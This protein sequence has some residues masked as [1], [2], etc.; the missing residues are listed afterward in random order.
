MKPSFFAIIVSTLM[1][2]SSFAVIVPISEVS[3]S[4]IEPPKIKYVAHDPIVII[5]DA[6][7]TAANGVTGGAGTPASPWL[8]EGWEIDAGGSN[9]IAISDTWDAF[10]IQNCYIYNAKAFDQWSWNEGRGVY[11][12]FVHDGN[13]VNTTFAN[14]TYGLRISQSWNVD[15]ELNTFINNSWTNIEVTLSNDIQILNNAVEGGSRSGN[16]AQSDDEADIFFFETVD[17]GGF[18]A[19]GGNQNGFGFASGSFQCA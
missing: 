16:R 13:I 17:K 5:G 10:L 19:R 9:G 2:V 15:V 6:D 4:A 8:I 18:K 11:L 12:D 14:N 3:G 7:F 1:I